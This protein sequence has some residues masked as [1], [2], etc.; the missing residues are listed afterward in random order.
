MR[1]PFDLRFLRFAGDTTDFAFTNQN[2]RHVFETNSVHEF[3]AP[4]DTEDRL[5]TFRTLILANA[6]A[7]VIFA[8]LR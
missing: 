1:S 4:F 8:V 6:S 7:V 2:S 5:L 3:S